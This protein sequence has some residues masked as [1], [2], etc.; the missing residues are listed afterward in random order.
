MRIIAF[1]LDR[2]TIERILDHIGEPTQPP[3][4]LPARSQPQ[5]EFGFDQAIATL[6]WPEMDQVAGQDGGWE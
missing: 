1:G 6:D 3:V 4:V 2:P 5:G